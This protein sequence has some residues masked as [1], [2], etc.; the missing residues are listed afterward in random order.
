MQFMDIVPKIMPSVLMTA[1]P[2]ILRYV[3]SVFIGKVF[4]PA[5]RVENANMEFAKII[6]VHILNYS[7]LS[8]DNI[9]VLREKVIHRYGL[10]NYQLQEMHDI[11]E[12]AYLFIW[13]SERIL[14]KE[15]EKFSR[16]YLE[17]APKLLDRD[18]FRTLSFKDRFLMYW[19]TYTSFFHEVFVISSI[20]FAMVS[21]YSAA[22]LFQ[23]ENLDKIGWMLLEG[24][25]LVSE[26]LFTVVCLF[27]GMVLGV[28]I[29]SFRDR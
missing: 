17:L 27:L 16:F 8:E 6:A 5:K 9:K 1:F 20:G 21:I 13:S 14:F 10:R 2:L 11:L 18:S 25:I 19:P 15:K 12:R 23:G 26:L 3:G 22:V 24:A 7:V 4:V 28:S 29:R